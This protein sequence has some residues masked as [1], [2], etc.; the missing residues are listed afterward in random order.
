MDMQ[1]FTT[2][3]FGGLGLVSLITSLFLVTE[4]KPAPALG[5]GL[6]AAVSIAAGFGVGMA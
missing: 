3:L 1:A 4:E 5:V 2:V 6:L